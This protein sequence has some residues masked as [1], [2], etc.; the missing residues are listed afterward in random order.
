M[1][2]VT[3][4]VFPVL[5]VIKDILPGQKNGIHLWAWVEMWHSD[6]LQRLELY[7]LCL[8]QELIHLGLSI[9]RSR[10]HSCG[11]PIHLNPCYGDIRNSYRLNEII[12]FS[13]PGGS[14]TFGMP[15]CISFVNC[16]L[17]GFLSSLSENDHFSSFLSLFPLDNGQR[18]G[19]LSLMFWVSLEAPPTP[20][21]PP[22]LNV[23]AWFSLFIF[24]ISLLPTIIDICILPA[25]L[26]LIKLW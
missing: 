7:R 23:L 8:C 4:E 11:R 25:V 3:L 1:I 9:I 15:A 18:L 5:E 24:S 14:S 10:K 20:C 26:F 16:G 21:W 12:H 13:L 17:L 19:V 2:W 22:L 6:L